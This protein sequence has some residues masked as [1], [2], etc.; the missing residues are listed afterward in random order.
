[1]ERVVDWVSPTL[2]ISSAIIKLHHVFKLILMTCRAAI[3]WLP[4]GPQKPPVIQYMLLDNNLEYL[5]YPK[6]CMV[7]DL[8]KTIHSIIDELQTRS[9]NDSLEVYY[10]SINKEFGRHRR[11]SGQFHRLIKKILGRQNLLKSNSR[12]AFLLK[13]EQLKLFKDALYLLDIDCKSKGNAFITHLWAI[14]LK[15]TRSRVP[16]VIKHIWKARFKIKRMNRAE[17]KNFQEFCS[18]LVKAF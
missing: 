6:E 3:R 4:K 14:A 15:A 12:L 16:I 18:H 5:I 17:E 2:G 10:K 1:V 13:K 8:K 9:G 7:I 11:D